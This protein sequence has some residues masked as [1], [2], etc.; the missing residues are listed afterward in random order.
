MLPENHQQKLLF[1][2]DSLISQK[3]SIVVYY[4][5]ILANS[6]PE[7]LAYHLKNLIRIKAK[8]PKNLNLKIHVGVSKNNDPSIGTPCMTLLP[9]LKKS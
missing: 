1:N 9:V 4:D 6:T 7:F 5:G 8:F 2:L 3:D